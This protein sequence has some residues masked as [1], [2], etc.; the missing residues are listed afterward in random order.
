M[1]MVSGNAKRRSERRRPYS[2]QGSTQLLE[3]KFLL[4]G[5]GYAKR[6]TFRNRLHDPGIDSLEASVHAKGIEEVVRVAELVTDL[7]QV[8]EGGYPPVSLS[9]TAAKPRHN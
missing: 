2:H 3:S 9:K 7:N 4:K 1:E 6:R 8:I 5:R